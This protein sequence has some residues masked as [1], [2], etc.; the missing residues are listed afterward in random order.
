[1]TRIKSLSTPGSGVAASPNYPANYPHRL[2]KTE[3]I[4]VQEGLVISLRFNAFDSE[5]H[6]TCKYDNLTIIDGVDGSTL[7]EKSCGSTKKSNGIL[8]G[9]QSIGTT[10]P[11]DITSTSNIVKLVFITNYKDTRPGWSVSWSAVAAGECQQHLWMFL[12]NFSIID[13]ALKNTRCFQLSKANQALLLFPLLNLLSFY[14]KE[15]LDPSFN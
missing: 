4:E 15:H 10:L 3:V 6:S 13:D 8:V 11:A 12:V 1:M 2:G 5:F 7:M 9:G 14:C